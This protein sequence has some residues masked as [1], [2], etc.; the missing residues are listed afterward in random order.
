[1]IIWDVGLMNM[2]MQNQPIAV[3]EQMSLAPFD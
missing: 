3:N 2:H 1:M